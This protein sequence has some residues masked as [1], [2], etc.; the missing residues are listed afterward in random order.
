MRK[1]TD[2]FEARIYVRN[3]RSFYQ[4]VRIAAIFL[5]FFLLIWLFAG[6]GYFWPIWVAFGWST[7]L[8]VRGIRLG[9]LDFLWIE[10]VFGMHIQQFTDQW[11]KQKVEDL[12]QSAEIAKGVTRPTAVPFKETKDKERKPSQ[13]SRKTKSKQKK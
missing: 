3:L 8:A 12:M 1:F 2:E 4:E 13:S 6:A 7:S 10:K 5:M 11:E 9:I